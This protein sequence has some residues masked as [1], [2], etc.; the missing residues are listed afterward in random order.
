ME[1][2]VGYS[3]ESID[4]LV[5]FDFGHQEGAAVDWFCSRPAAG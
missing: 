3:T 4:G 2:G 5:S 1:V